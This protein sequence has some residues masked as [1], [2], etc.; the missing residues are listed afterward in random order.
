MVPRPHQICVANL[1]FYD[2]GPHCRTL[3]CNYI[4]LKWQSVSVQSKTQAFV[5][6]SGPIVR[7]EGGMSA[8]KI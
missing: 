5:Q 6:N 8:P 2:W 4:T 1:T 3:G 7:H